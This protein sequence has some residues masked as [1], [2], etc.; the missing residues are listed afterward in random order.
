MW[1]KQSGFTYIELL[2]VIISLG[3]LFSIAISSYSNVR[4]RSLDQRRQS[5][6]EEIRS[7]LEQYRSVNTAYP[8]PAGV[9]GM[10]FG[11]G[12]LTDGTSTYMEKIPQDPQ[13]PVRQYH[14]TTSGDDYTL[15][16]ELSSPKPTVC[17]AAPGGDSCG[18]SGSGVGC[19]YCLGSYGEK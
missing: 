6:M 2:I 7:A 12:S 5:D 1:N 13:H 9:Q 10:T 8:T 11:T 17:Q 15:S 16:T 14:Y 18:Q 4:Q 19:N 3:I